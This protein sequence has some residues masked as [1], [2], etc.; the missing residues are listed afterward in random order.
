MNRTIKDATVKRCHY[1]THDQVSRHLGDVI[2]AYNAARRLKTRRG[3]TPYDFI[4]Q[5]WT[6]EPERFD[7]NPLQA[8][9]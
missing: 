4:C 2:D 8:R 7:L 1:D 6:K 9:D 5:T 3:P